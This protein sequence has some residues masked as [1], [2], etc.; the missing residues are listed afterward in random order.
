MS[1]NDHANDVQGGYTNYIAYR[2]PKA[3]GQERIGHLD[4]QK[5]IIQP[6]SFASGTPISNLYQVIEIGEL[7]IKPSGEVV[8]LSVFPQLNC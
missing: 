2:D 4:L 3:L 6:L 7:N 8:A 5:S 1:A